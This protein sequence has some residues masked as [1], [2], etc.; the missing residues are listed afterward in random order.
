MKWHNAHVVAWL[1]Y[2][3]LPRVASAVEKEK[4]LNGSTLCQMHTEEMGAFIKELCEAVPLLKT[5][6]SKEEKSPDGSPMVELN[7]LK[8]TNIWS[9]VRYLQQCVQRGHSK[10]S[11]ASWEQFLRHGSSGG[12]GSSAGGRNFARQ[13]SDI[14]DTG[15]RTMLFSFVFNYFFFA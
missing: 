8:S 15:K 1:R 14:Q 13:S 4:S 10:G 7:R 2:L 3:G 5:L 11:A 12:H 6:E 9:N